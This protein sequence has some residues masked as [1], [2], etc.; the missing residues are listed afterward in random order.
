MSQMPAEH[1]ILGLLAL[2]DGAGHGYDL[3]R[4]FGEGRP[5]AAVLRLEVGMLYHPLKKL[6]RAG[7]V[8]PVAGAAESRPPRQVYALTD[9]GRAELVRWLGEPVAHTREIRLEFLVK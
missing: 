4:H 3:S 1:A 9:A 6:A 2:E 7:W 5:L 8:A